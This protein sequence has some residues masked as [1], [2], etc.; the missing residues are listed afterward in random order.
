MPLVLDLENDL[1]SISI[2]SGDSSNLLIYYQEMGQNLQGAPIYMLKSE[3]L[4]KGVNAIAEL[5]YISVTWTDLNS[6]QS[7]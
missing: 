6:W 1:I 4:K 2:E 7:I 3:V 5:F